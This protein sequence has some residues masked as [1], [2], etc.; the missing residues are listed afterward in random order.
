MVEPKKILT[1]SAYWG[2]DTLSMIKSKYPNSK[3][4]IGERFKIQHIKYDETHIAPDDN[5]DIPQSTW[6][7]QIPQNVVSQLNMMLHPI[8]GNKEYA[9]YSSMRDIDSVVILSTHV[10][11]NSIALAISKYI[12]DECTKH[13]DVYMEDDENAYGMTMFSAPKTPKIYMLT[14]YPEK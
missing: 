14:I 12:M 2:D 4:R 7:L 6:S 3:N 1:I 9:Q 8:S 11:E 10:F 13:W 5:D